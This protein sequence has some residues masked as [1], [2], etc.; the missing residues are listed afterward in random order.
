MPE[1]TLI[2]S[3]LREPYSQ[4]LSALYYHGWIH[5]MNK[6]HQEP[7]SVFFNELSEAEQQHLAT[8]RMSTYFMPDVSHIKQ[9]T[10]SDDVIKL[11]SKL[12]TLAQRIPFVVITEYFDHSLVL[13]RRIM[14]WETSDIVYTQMKHGN[15]KD[16]IDYTNETYRN[17]YKSD[18][19][20]DH[21]LYNFYNNSLWRRMKNEPDDFWDE[22]AYFKMVNKNI[23]EFCQPVHKSL[24]RNAATLHSIIKD[25]RTLVFPATRWGSGFT[26]DVTQC[27]LMAVNEEAFRNILIT[28]QYPQVSSYLIYL[29]HTMHTLS[30][31]CKNRIL[32]QVLLSIWWNVQ[33]KY[34]L[35][36]TRKLCCN[37]NL[38]ITVSSCQLFEH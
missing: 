28:K 20:L 9:Y 7:L 29:I 33:T 38:C 26:I 25:T 27:V 37:A 23:S 15:Y 34:L 1:D 36:W 17:R 18:T 30:Q 16:S 2:I 6:T 19:F 12:L 8:P 11:S 22:L 24:E 10:K 31:H 13:L 4:L 35:A 14:C 21:A 3:S 5:T 32:I